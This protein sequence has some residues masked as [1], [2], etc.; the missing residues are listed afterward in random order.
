MQGGDGQGP[1]C[2]DACTKQTAW[3]Y[4]PA[5]HAFAHPSPSPLSTFLQWIHFSPL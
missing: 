3:L 2:R 4:K 1:K 5:L